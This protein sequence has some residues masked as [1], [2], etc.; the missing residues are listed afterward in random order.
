MITHMQVATAVA[1]AAGY[2]AA[3]AAGLMTKARAPRWVLGA[4]TVVLSTLA[5]V[6][7]TVAWRPNDNWK[8]SL[9]NVFAALLTATLAHRSQIPEAIQTA[10]PHTGVGR[11]SG[12]GDLVTILLVVLIVVS[13]VILLPLH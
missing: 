13:I 1:L 5:G 11:E 7:P 9:A 12:H 6:L 3:H 2:F 10:T 4:V 8:V